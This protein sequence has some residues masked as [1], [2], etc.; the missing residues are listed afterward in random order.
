MFTTRKQTFPIVF[1][2]F[3]LFYNQLVIFTFRGH[4]WA[5]QASSQCFFH[6]CLRIQARTS[7]AQGR[8]LVAQERILVPQVRILVTGAY[9]GCRTGLYTVTLIIYF[10]IYYT[11]WSVAIWKL[12]D[13]LLFDVFFCSG[14]ASGRQQILAKASQPRHL[15][16]GISAKESQQGISVKRVVTWLARYPSSSIL[17]RMWDQEIVSP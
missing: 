13:C 10:P 7:S 5:S 17:G 11:K 6:W 4:I 3:R 8:I 2:S 9:S 12:K 14:P 1:Q 16:Q 15:S